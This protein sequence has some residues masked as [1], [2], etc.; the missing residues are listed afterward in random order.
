MTFSTQVLQL[1]LA[2]VTTGSIYSLI[3]L[4]FV[5]IYN[6]TGIINF[7]QGEFV[8]LGALS[9]ISL[10]S[11]GLPMTLAILFSILAVA[12]VGA[13]IQRLAIRP[14]RHASVITLII[15]TIGA[16][17]AL[18]GLALIL[19]GSDPY[20]LPAFSPGGPIAIFGAVINRQSLWVLGITAVTL[21][22][23]FLFFEYTLV[24]KAVRA[25]AIN[26]RAARLMGIDTDRMAR[27][28]FALAA[29]LGAIS[30]IVIAPI[31]LPTYDMG[32][33]LGL[34]GFVAAAMGGLVSTQG[35]VIG[36]LLLGVL[37]SLGAGLISS[38]Y[39]DA[40]AFLILIGILLAR[41]EGI[42]SPREGA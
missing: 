2:G 28:S 8:T 29:A 4:G 37:E 38:G 15:I 12:V 1:V 14:A 30:G 6:V 16:D 39:K 18:R 42:L 27:L 26:A 25:C 11:L 21:A 13:L 9:T 10:L 24:G 34:K 19:W 17:I 41:S 33:M 40:I 31:T 32:L 36:G 22:A 7:A 5:T 20:I 35:A 23:L 3:A